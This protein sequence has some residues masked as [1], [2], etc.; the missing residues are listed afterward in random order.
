ML[1]GTALLGVGGAAIA[2]QPEPIAVPVRKEALDKLIPLQIG[3]WT[4]RDASGIVLPPPDALSDALY[5]GLV[6]RSYVSPDRLP[7]MLLVAYSNVQD[8]MLQVHRPEVCY[9]AGGYHLS[10]TQVEQVPNGVGGGISANI[11]SADGISR[12][13]QVLYWTRIGNSFP[14]SWLD[15]RM[16]VVRANL[17]G[18]I[19]DGILVR[20]STLAPDMPAAQADLAAFAA[21]LVES[22]SPAA[23]QLLIGRA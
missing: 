13:E 9:P 2:R 5:S 23:R 14:T 22:A 11:F 8:G 10:P 20:L 12:T 7:M 18:M 21:Q 15:Q 17:D 19:P 3:N 1:I 16:A 4:Y 6:T